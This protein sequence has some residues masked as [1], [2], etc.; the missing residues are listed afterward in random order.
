MAQ[1]MDGFQEGVVR[2]AHAEGEERMQKGQYQK[3]TAIMQI[4]ELN[5][6][7]VNLQLRNQLRQIQL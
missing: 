7:F 6:L 4:Q 3:R 1:I 2:T 5:K